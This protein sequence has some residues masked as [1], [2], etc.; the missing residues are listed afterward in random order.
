MK[1]GEIHLVYQS[2]RGLRNFGGVLCWQRTPSMKGKDMQLRLLMKYSKR[3]VYT[4]VV[5]TMSPFLF[6][7]AN[8][9]GTCLGLATGNEINVKK[10]VSMGFKYRGGGPL[11]APTGDMFVHLCS[12]GCVV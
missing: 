1:S 7:Q 3:W 9:E 4:N 12:K 2:P 8:A 6:D 10:Y 5:R 11:P